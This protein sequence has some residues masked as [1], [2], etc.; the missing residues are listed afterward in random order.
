MGFVAIGRNEGERLKV[1]LR[2][3]RAVSDRV[4]Y[5]DSGSTDG[6]VDFARGAGCATLVLDDSAKFTMARARNAGWRTLIDQWPD[7]EFVHFLDGDCEL[8]AS[9]IDPAMDVLRAEETVA[10][11]CGRRRE[12]FPEAS[13][14]NRL[15]E[16]EWNTPVGEA[17][18]CGGDAI[19]RRAALDQVGGYNESLIAGEEP[20]MCLRLRK[21]GWR[22]RRIDADMTRHDAN[23]LRFRQWWNRSRR[24]G[25]GAADVAARTAADPDSGEVLFGSQVRSA[26]NW[27]LGLCGVLGVAMILAALGFRWIPL[28]LVGLAIFGVLAQSIRIALGARDRAGSARAALEYGLLTMLAKIPQALGIFQYSGDQ[29]ARR[30]STLIEYKK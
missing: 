19:F 16:T 7:T 5:V 3:L 28:F 23:I 1:C 26:M 20:E 30:T 8:I 6:S 2:S 27:A 10:A 21:R 22:I 24:G 11:V 25:Y 18:S 9:W 29:R 12:R 14:Y 15:C 4:V 17:K 13:I